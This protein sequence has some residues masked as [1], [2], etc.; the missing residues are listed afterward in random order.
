MCFTNR[1]DL[2]PRTQIQFEPPIELK[3]E[4]QVLGRNWEPEHHESSL[5]DAGAVE[6]FLSPWKQ[7]DWSKIRSE[8]VKTAHNFS[9]VKGMNFGCIF[10][11]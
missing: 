4:L 8:N 11:A 1:I 9:Q 3:E 6:A 5:C 10:T 2:Q 7:S